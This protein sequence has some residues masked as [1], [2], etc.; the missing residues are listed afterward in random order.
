MNQKRKTN[1]YAEWMIVFAVLVF[2][3]WFFFRDIVDTGALIGDRGDGRLCTLLAEHWWNF[4]TGKEK[5]S[6]IAM[7]YPAEGVIGYTDL[8]LGYGI[9]H[10]ILRLFGVNMF[11]AYKWTLVLTHIMGTITMYYLLKKKMNI[12]VIWALF[13]TMAFS[14]SDTFARHLGHTQ[15]DAVCYLPL[16]LIFFIGFI[17][18]Y[19]KRA[20]RNIYGYF[21]VVW[22]VLLTYSSWYIACFTGLFC[23]I[24]LVTYFICLKKNQVLIWPVFKEKILFIWKDLIGYL[25]VM[26]VLYIPF[27]QVYLPVLIS[28]SG[29][30]YTECAFF[31]PEFADIINVTEDNLM[32]GWFIEKLGL[33]DRGYSGEVTEGFSIILLALFITMALINKKSSRIVL[34]NKESQ[35][36]LFKFGMIKAVFISVIIAILCIIRLSANGVSLW[37]VVYTLVPVVR[38]MRAVSRFLLWLSFPMAVITAY[39]ANKYISIKGKGT[40]ACAV[41]AV[42]LIFISNINTT[43]VSQSWNFTDEWNFITS[44]SE[45][46]EDAE[47]FYIIDTANTGD[48]PYIYQLDAYEI[49][50]YYSIKTINGYSGHSPREWDGIWEV[51]SRGYESAVFAWIEKYNLKNV[52]AYD[53]AI[54]TWISYEDRVACTM[55]DV[56]CPAENK[57]S[58]SSGLED[59]NQGDYAWTSQE[60]ETQIN[61]SEIKNTGLVIKMQLQLS[62]YIAQN[63]ELIPYIQIFVDGELVQDVEVTDEFVELNIPMSEH[64]GDIYDIKIKTNCYFNPKDI[65]INEDARNLS[66]GMYYIGN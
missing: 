13:G 36:K 12:N 24:F 44:V 47:S 45:P 43:G 33:S 14:F 21:F 62:N 52:Y 58:L 11:V 23:L 3:E 5:F 56:F 39:T 2:C 59:W 51:C 8:L 10:S 42:A 46:P 28:S 64:E 55:D 17:E 60:F 50:N 26:I 54:N 66:I 35:K 53:R 48:A 16:L 38:S 61:N 27:I 20:K 40:F 57:F 31:L 30:S 25:V 63:P 18:N 4:F 9:L 37:Y 6:E 19:E 49:A 15:L 7:F 32:F 1:K 34:E 22:F 65:G 41:C 29:Y